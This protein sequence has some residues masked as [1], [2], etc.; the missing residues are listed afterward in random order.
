MDIDAL[1]TELAAG[2]PVT[3]AYVADHAAAAAQFHKENI[4]RNRTS[5]TGREVAAE[6]V[7]SEYDVLTDAKKAQIIALTAHDDI[8]PYGFAANVVKDVFGAGS[9]TVVSLATARTET[10]SQAVDKS[11]GDVTAGDIQRARA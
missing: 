4:I 11:L 10:V 1:K 6:I 7:D 8:D 3:L 9:D 2:H 5:M